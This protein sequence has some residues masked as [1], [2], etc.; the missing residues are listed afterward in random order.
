MNAQLNPKGKDTAAITPGAEF[1][2]LNEWIE[3][4]NFGNEAIPLSN[5]SVSHKFLDKNHRKTPVR[6]SYW[7]GE[8]QEL[9]LPMQKL[10]IRSG[11]FSDYHLI[12]DNQTNVL[13]GFANRKRFVFNNQWGGAITISWIDSF[14]RRQSNRFLYDA[15]QSIGAIHI[16]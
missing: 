15:D 11:N 6:E 2:L 10:R 13:N 9:L 12:K 4:E 3:I 8:T 1:N 7:S 16:E 14:G 5:I